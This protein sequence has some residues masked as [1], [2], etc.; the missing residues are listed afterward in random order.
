MWCII[1]SVR[2]CDILVLIGHAPTEDTD[3][4]KDR[5]YEELERVFDKIRK[6]HDKI[7]LEDFIA[8]VGRLETFK[9]T[10][11]NES[12]HKISNDNGIMETAFKCT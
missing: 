7:F 1:L 5:F 3:Y 8:K 9:A 10:I 4:M 11:G 2:W 12:F 6:H